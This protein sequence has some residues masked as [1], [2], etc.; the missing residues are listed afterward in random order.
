MERIRITWRHGGYQR[1]SA[2]QNWVPF[3]NIKNMLSGRANFTTAFENVGG[4]IIIFIPFGILVP[5]LLKGKYKFLKTLF[6]G[7]ALSAFFEFFQLYTGCGQFD[8]DD[9]I[10]NTAGTLAGLIFFGLGSL[11]KPRP[12]ANYSPTD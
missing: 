7:F 8:V 3:K 12:H 11:L 5:L 2:T 10:L 9:I 4:N 1:S 6:L